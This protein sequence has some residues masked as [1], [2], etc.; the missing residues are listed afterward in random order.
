MGQILP[1]DNHHR[2]LL[3]LFVLFL[4]YGLFVLLRVGRLRLC[5]PACK[6]NNVVVAY[7]TFLSRVILS[8]IMWIQG[9]VIS[10]AIRNARDI[11]SN[12]QPFV[13]LALPECH[14]ER[15]M[16]VVIGNR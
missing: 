4:I 7:L 15:T 3:L 13:C 5:A 14:K 9:G 6:V 11:L 8:C 10:L 1:S 2:M 12:A 16:H